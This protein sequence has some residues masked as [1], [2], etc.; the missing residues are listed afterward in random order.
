MIFAGQFIHLISMLAVDLPPPFVYLIQRMSIFGLIEGIYSKI[1]L[2]QYF[3]FMTTD[4]FYRANY[5]TT[6]FLSNQSLS[7][8]IVIG[9]VGG[10]VIKELIVHKKDDESKVQELGINGF[11]ESNLNT[12]KQQKMKEIVWNKAKVTGFNIFAVMFPYVILH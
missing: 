1:F 2:L 8:F 3:N 7:L 6:S 11:D 9:I 4:R 10:Y 5:E 12:D